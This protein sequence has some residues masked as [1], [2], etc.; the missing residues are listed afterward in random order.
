MHIPVPLAEL[1]H[2]VDIPVGTSACRD[3]HR[4]RQCLIELPEDRV[5]IFVDLELFA[6][7]LVFR[8][9]FLKIGVQLPRRH[10]WQGVKTDLDLLIA[11]YRVFNQAHVAALR[12]DGSPLHRPLL[13]LDP[14][15]GFGLVQRKTHGLRNHRRLQLEREVADQQ[16]GA[17]PLPRIVDIVAP[18]APV[19][20]FAR[21]RPDGRTDHAVA[22][23]RTVRIARRCFIKDK[24]MWTKDLLIID[25]PVQGVIRGKNRRCT[26]AADEKKRS[27]YSVVHDQVPSSFPFR[28]YRPKTLVTSYSTPFWVWNVLTVSP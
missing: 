14:A 5:A 22:D 8:E 1:C 13:R 10:G 21:S 4:R 27:W 3:T 25:L 18:E 26:A 2:P 24:I 7:P 19:N 12:S 15:A 6:G 11:F 23:K 28:C 16:A 9:M 17:A 20:R